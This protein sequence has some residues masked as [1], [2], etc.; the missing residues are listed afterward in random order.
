MHVSKPLGLLIAA[1]LSTSPAMGDE[2]PLRIGVDV[3]YVPYQYQPARRQHHR[4][5]G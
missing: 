4:L 3:P 5:R 1:A 2:R